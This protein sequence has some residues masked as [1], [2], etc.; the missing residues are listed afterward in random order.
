MKKRTS[1]QTADAF[2]DASTRAIPLAHELLTQAEAPF[3]TAAELATSQEARVATNA[4]LLLAYG[5]ELGIRPMMARSGL[6]PKFQ[7]QVAKAVCG[8][9]LHF[10]KRVIAWLENQLVDRTLV[11]LPGF[12]VRTDEP[13]IPRRVCDH[14]Y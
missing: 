4:R 9:E 5:I 1:E 3:E 11:P 7:T 6:E 10:R 2:A 8:A 12:A 13:D 14:A